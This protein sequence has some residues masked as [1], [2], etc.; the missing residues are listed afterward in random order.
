M[1]IKQGWQ[2]ENTIYIINKYKNLFLGIY[3]FLN[4]KKE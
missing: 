4:L 1:K 3:Y 2:R